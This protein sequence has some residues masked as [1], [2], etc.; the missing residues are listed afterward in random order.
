MEDFSVWLPQL[1][2]T[3]NSSASYYTYMYIKSETMHYIVMKHSQLF[4]F[5]EMVTMMIYYS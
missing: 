3:G 1:L 4:F 5:L 2:N